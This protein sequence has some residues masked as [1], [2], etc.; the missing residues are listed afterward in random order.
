MKA[1]HSILIVIIALGIASPLAAQ[2]RSGVS[3]AGN[4]TTF[5][6]QILA[7]DVQG[8]YAYL[9]TNLT[10]LQIL[11]VSNPENMRRVG[12]HNPPGGQVLDVYVAGNRA[13][14]AYYHEG[15]SGFRV[16]DVS[17][18]AHPAEIGSWEDPGNGNHYPRYIAVA[19]DFLYGWGAGTWNWSLTKLNVSD[20][21]HI[22]FESELQSNWGYSFA[23]DGRYCFGD[24]RPWG[25]RSL[26]IFDSEGEVN[27][28][29]DNPNPRRIETPQ[30][31][32]DLELQ[33]NLLYVAVG[34]AGVMVFD[35]SDPMEPTEI[36]QYDTPGDVTAL[37]IEGDRAYVMESGRFLAL[38]ISDPE[39]LREV[40][41]DDWPVGVADWQIS[42]D[43][44]F[45]SDGGPN[46]YI[47]NISNPDDISVIGSYSRP[48]GSSFQSIALSDNYAYVGDRA[49][50]RIWIIDPSIPRDVNWIGDFNPLCLATSGNYLFAGRGWGEWN[51]AAWDISNPMSPERVLSLQV[52]LHTYDIEVRDDL[53]FSL[54]WVEWWWGVNTIC[55]WDISDIRNPRVILERFDLPG[56]VRKFALQGDYV[57][58]ACGGNGLV[59]VDISDVAHPQVVATHRARWSADDVA[60][61]GAYAYVA[62][63]LAG[64]RVIDVSNPEEPNE[65]GFIGPRGA[66]EGWE[67]PTHFVTID[68]DFAYVSEAENGIRVI[69]IA[70]PEHP[71]EVGFYDTPNY[72]YALAVREPYAFAADNDR[73]S[74]YDC[75][76]ATQLESGETTVD[77]RQGW[78]IISLNVIPDIRRFG[79]GGRGA[80][81]VRML[82]PLRVDANQHHVLLMKDEIGR[83]YAPRWGY[84]NIPYWD[85]EDGY[86]IKLDAEAQTVWSG[87]TIPAQRPLD[88]HQGWNLIAYYPPYELSAEAP[89]CYV[90]S[91]ILEHVFLARDED[92]RFMVPSAEFSNMPPWRPSRGYQVW[93]DANV[94]LNYPEEQQ[95]N[96]AQPPRRPESKGRWS[97]PV[98]TAECMNV[99]VT[100]SPPYPALQS[101]GGEGGVE[102]GSQVAAFDARGRIVGVGESLGGRCGLAVWGDDPTTEAVD[103]MSDNESFTLKIWAVASGMEAGLTPLKFTR[104]EALIYQPNDL[105]TLE[106]KAEAVLPQSFYLAAAYPNPFN[107]TTRITFG[108]PAAQDVRIMVWDLSGRYVAELLDETRPAGSYTLQWNAGGI[109]SGVYLL[110]METGGFVAARKLVIVK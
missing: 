97:E 22:S 71:E 59:I 73:F 31:V 79:G 70:D 30:V 100:I 40:G 93:V 42:G 76:E 34:N 38:D 10:G 88:L 102:N 14:V 12:W 109:A 11:D 41:Y 64:L 81:V 68:G 18:P 72:T 55:C 104:G 69:S 94:T 36:S 110:R 96:A 85:R 29:G 27:W 6:H 62:D 33:G 44:A 106:V 86:K 45:V 8:D 16:V 92:G 57:Y 54:Q 99:L 21:E 48:G 15:I 9:A 60:V 4:V 107:A 5:W 89:E 63:D 108:L 77:M 49:T 24:R 52:P 95:R 74:I 80:D 90:L 87:T 83:F 7:A 23:T 98:A 43:R 58:V 50:G 103:G 25:E 65:V 17:D 13:Y 51:I 53:L 105:L 75:S 37:R 101:G 82:E 3:L 35:V 84:N 67:R 28:G 39:N 66:G 32:Y 61:S 19:G 26:M 2:D 91:P 47:L 56:D 1:W 46:Y 78:S 20:P